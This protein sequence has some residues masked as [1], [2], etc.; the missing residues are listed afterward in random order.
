MPSAID[1]SI[2]IQE[3][4]NELST[5]AISLERENFNLKRA[6]RIFASNIALDEN[7]VSRVEITKEE[8]E[9]IKRVCIEYNVFLQPEDKTPD[10]GYMNIENY[11]EED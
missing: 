5:H 1:H 10:K 8:A 9:Y 7:G 11:D 4:V 6:L 3:K 2:K